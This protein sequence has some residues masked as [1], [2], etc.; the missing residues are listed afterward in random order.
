MTY[1]EAAALPI[2]KVV[3]RVS[4]KTGDHIVNLYERVK[5]GC[6]DY[7]DLIGGAIGAKACTQGSRVYPIVDDTPLLYFVTCMLLFF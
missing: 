5:K 1:K 4:E 2:S 6:N 7:V 3:K